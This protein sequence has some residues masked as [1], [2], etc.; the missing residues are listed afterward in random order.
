MLTLGACTGHSKA[1]DG[2]PSTGISIITT[3]ATAAPTV[4]AG[5][6]GETAPSGTST[7]IRSTGAPAT[8]TAPVA[9]NETEAPCPY[10][11]N[12]QAEDLEGNRV[13]R[14]VVINTVPVGCR[15]YFAYGDGH[16]TLEITTQTFKTTVQAYNA[17]VSAGGP[18]A[19]GV[20]GLADDGVLYVTDFY[21]PDKGKDWACTFAK[22]LTIVTIKTDQTSP[23]L[24]AKL[25]AQAVAPQI[26]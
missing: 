11:T 6:S 8:S 26:P 20:P 10:L 22:G 3:D 2:S 17:M 1:S 24:N 7:V 21:A 25:V 19:V 15:F 16:A 9:A 18:G 5:G 23:S 13:G 14:S 12:V 4:I